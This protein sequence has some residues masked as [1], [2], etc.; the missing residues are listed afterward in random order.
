[1]EVRKLGKTGLEVSVIGFGGIPIQRI[2]FEEAHVLV[3]KALDLGINFFDTARGYTDSEAKIGAVLRKRRS[4]AV[5]AT[6]SMART[7]EKMAADIRK[8]L[9]TLGVDFIDL[10]QIHNV[11]DRSTLERVLAPDGALAAL[12]EAKREGL[13]K[14]I[15]I[16]GHVKSVLLEALKIREFETVQ[17]PFNVV[18]N[19]G[20]QE[21]LQLAEMHGVGTIVMKPLAGGALKNSDLA[22]RYLLEYPVSTVIPGM[23]SVDQV[24]RNVAV[25]DNPSPLSPSERELLMREAEQLGRTFCRRCDYCQPCP[26]GIN[27]PMVLLFD[28]YY[29]RYDLKEW[30]RERYRSLGVKVEAC[31]DCGACEE[32]CPYNLP[33]R[34]LLRDAAT[35]L[36]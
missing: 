34:Q 25:G 33:V 12:Q 9:K 36:S 22:L 31:V 29:L 18:E 14:H 17:F 13:V 26:Q 28:G 23:D 35:R 15:G 7:K 27:I 21:L 20:V 24:E 4:E 1:M 10:Y 19:E 32:K 6:K 8:S 11:R 30:A 3:N 16:T 5:I 2:S